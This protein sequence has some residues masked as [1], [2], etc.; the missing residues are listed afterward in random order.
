MLELTLICLNNQIWAA[1]SEN[2]AIMPNL[3]SFDVSC[4]MSHHSESILEEKTNSSPFQQL[5][6]NQIFKHYNMVFLFGQIRLEG[7]KLKK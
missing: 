6:A 2:K 4:F 1:K 5:M 3:N 7:L